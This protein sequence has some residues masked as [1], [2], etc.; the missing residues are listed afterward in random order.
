MCHGKFASHLKNLD[1]D[2]S[3]TK[4]NLPDQRIAG[5]ISMTDGGWVFCSRFATILVSLFASSAMAAELNL[6]QY[7]GSP[8]TPGYYTVDDISQRHEGKFISPEI[9]LTGGISSFSPAST[10][11]SLLKW[12][13][14]S[15][16]ITN[17]A[18][19]Y[20]RLKHF[21]TWI[22]DPS[23]S[24]CLNTRG[25]ILRRESQTSVTYTDTKECTIA[26]GQ[27][28]EPY[29]GSI[30]R[31]AGE[32]QIDHVVP[33]KNAYV[34][35]AWQWS[36]KQRCLYANFMTNNFHLL[37]VDSRENMRKGDRAPDRYMPPNGSF[38]CEYLEDW[39]KIK[40]IWNLKMTASEG[41]AI[42]S[43]MVTHNCDPSVYSMTRLELDR[44]R[45]ALQSFAKK[46]SAESNEPIS[47]P[48]GIFQSP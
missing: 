9:I 40:L 8:Q 38:V 32:L 2:P 45:A 29:T 39:L 5:L 27:W 43:E 4:N 3:L 12:I 1:L 42:Q 30:K 37:A 21:G 33:L 24:T 17:P 31:N 41:N 46:C 44:E 26:T 35:G 10:V 47:N 19:A 7:E 14:H 16:A 6:G 25:L 34:M 48:N 15:E 18:D 11:L 13:S 28:Y 20:N 23:G 22:T 36:G